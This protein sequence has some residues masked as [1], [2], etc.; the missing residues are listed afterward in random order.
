M[1]VNVLKRFLNVSRWWFRPTMKMIVRQKVNLV[2]EQAPMDR[3]MMT[4]PNVRPNVGRVILP[5]PEDVKTIIVIHLRRLHTN[6]IR[7]IISKR[8]KQRG[9]ELNEDLM[10]WELILNSR[11]PL[12]G[13]QHEQEQRGKMTNS[14]KPIIL[15]R[16]LLKPQFQN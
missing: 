9:E 2:I 6:T 10:E 14:M 16:R 13:A 8:Q 7:I 1:I 5:Q 15:K 12:G 3:I 11:T 4:V